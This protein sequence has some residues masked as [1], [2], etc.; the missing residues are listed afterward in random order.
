MFKS[1]TREGYF[2]A[3]DK[4]LSRLEKY[5]LRLN[6]KKCIFGV[7]STKLLGLIVSERGI[8]VDPN[9]IKVI[10]EMP[11]PKKEKDVRGFIGKF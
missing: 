5:N 2:E 8:E 9:N 4:F 7:T 6:M 10:Q 3:L 1:E 11:M